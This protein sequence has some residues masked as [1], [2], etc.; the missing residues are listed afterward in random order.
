M[1]SSKKKE[2]NNEPTEQS[3]YITLFV[4]YFN[5]ISNLEKEYLN[6]I[7]NN[8]NE[9]SLNI[10]SAIK[11]NLSFFKILLDKT[12]PEYL[13]ITIPVDS[14]G[15]MVYENNPN[16]V[17]YQHQ[18]KI[19]LD[20]LETIWLKYYVIKLWIDAGGLISPSISAKYFDKFEFIKFLNEIEKKFDSINKDIVKLYKNKYYNKLDE[21]KKLRLN[22]YQIYLLLKNQIKNITLENM[23]KIVKYYNMGLNLNLLDD[24]GVIKMFECLEKY[25]L[26]KQINDIVDTDLI[27][28]EKITNEN[29]YITIDDKKLKINEYKKKYFANKLNNF[30][31]SPDYKKYIDKIFNYMNELQNLDYEFNS[32]QRKK[33]N[34]INT[35]KLNL[36]TSQYRFNPEL[37]FPLFTPEELGKL[38]EQILTDI[39]D[40]CKVMKDLFPYYGISE[41]FF[42]SKINYQ[43]H[44]Q[45]YSNQKDID[46]TINAYCVIMIIIGLVNYKLIKTQQ[47][48][49]IIIKGGKALQL[50]LSEIYSNN[51]TNIQ[52]KSN[53]IDLIIN[54]NSCIE[55]NELECKNLS[56]NLVEL[57][58]WMLNKN[59]N[60]Y[61]ADNYITNTTGQEYKTLIKL[62]HKI[63]KYQDTDYLSSY[64]ALVDLDYGKKNDMFYDNL[65]IDEKV[66]KYGKLLFVYQNLDDFI[67]EKM[68]YLDF[69]IKE[70]N[71]LKNKYMKEKG[72]CTTQEAKT[73][74]NNFINYERFV[75]KFSSQI[76]QALKIILY[77]T[78]HETELKP[79]TKT[80][81]ENQINKYIYK[82]TEKNKL[83]YKLN[84]KN[85][86]QY[87]L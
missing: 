75:D 33:L 35:L 39:N 19:I 52:Y 29:K 56:N 85:I 30:I 10:K 69:Y 70:I 34:A 2:F 71:K 87:L 3:I 82:L 73:D 26:D 15:N 43:T 41:D 80:E 38:K 8:N 28:Y 22:T 14:V 40:I 32:K 64:T 42:C 4:E 60:L 65:I 1:F 72:Q 44:E 36:T 55:Y 54:P 68:Y 12:K 9:I 74:V 51:K 59:N 53:D 86:Q 77:K 61:D 25:Y 18:Y 37:W 50:L 13:N 62:S 5:K 45:S 46:R 84:F 78:E 83:V 23:E 16:I 66:S 57:I 31:F 6:A 76:K 58:K 17:N 79:E 47:N 24:V 48:Y 63:Q 21:D 49:Q 67:L 7:N 81:T 20:R 11:K 27:E